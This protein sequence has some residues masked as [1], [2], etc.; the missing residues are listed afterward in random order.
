[1]IEPQITVGVAGKASLD[2]AFDLRP[3]GFQSVRGQLGQPME[4]TLAQSRSNMA[5]R[6]AEVLSDQAGDVVEPAE[7]RDP[8]AALGMGVKRGNSAAQFL[9][10]AAAD[11]TL[12]EGGA[13]RCV[14]GK[15]HIFTAHSM[16]SPEPSTRRLSPSRVTGTTSR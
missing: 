10:H 11:V 7:F 5:H 9:N 15:P 2:T 14:F 4:H 16:T 8:R 1:M 13:Q 6:L 12:F 3:Q